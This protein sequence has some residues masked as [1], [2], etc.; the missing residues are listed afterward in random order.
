MESSSAAPSG[1]VRL[2][3]DTIAE[4]LSPNYVTE[5]S[6]LFKTGK[7]VLPTFKK[8]MDAI[9]VQVVSEINYSSFHPHY[10]FNNGIRS[11]DNPVTEEDIL[12]GQCCYPNMDCVGAAYYIRQ[13]ILT[14]LTVFDEES[15]FLI[16]GF[17]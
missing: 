15:I 8:V 17:C 12:E 7:F 13:K 9:L 4:I 16:Y 1:K 5:V 10:I 11:Q 6:T 14:T 2:G 3:E